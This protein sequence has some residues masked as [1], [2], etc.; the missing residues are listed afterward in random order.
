M[1]NEQNENSDVDMLVE[2]AAPIELLAFVDLKNYLPDL[3][4]INVDLVMKRVL[5]PK[6]G[7]RVLEEAVSPWQTTDARCCDLNGYAFWARKRAGVLAL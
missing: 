1:R 2:F 7:Q 6:A 5:K 3:L 4:E